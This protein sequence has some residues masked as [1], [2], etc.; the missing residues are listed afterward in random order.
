MDRSPAAVRLARCDHR[1][2]PP[3]A[4]RLRAL[5]PSCGP[6]RLVAVDGH[7]GSGKSTFAGRLAE[8]LGGAPV[9]HL[10]DLATH[11]EL[12]AWTD[13]LRAQVLEPLAAGRDRPLRR[14]TTGSRA[15]FAGERE[16]PPAPVVLLEGVG[17]GRRALRPHLARLLWMELARRARPGR[18]G[19][20]RD[21]PGAGALLGRLDRGGAT[22]TSRRTP[23]AR[24]R[25]SW[26]ARRMTGYE[27]LPGPPRRADR[28]RSDASRD[29]DDSA[30]A[31][32]R[33]RTGPAGVASTRLD[34]GGVQDLRSQCAV[35]TDRPQTRSPRLFPRD[36]GLRS[37]PDPV[38]RPSG[39]AFPHPA[40]PHLRA[41]AS[42][43][44]PALAASRPLRPARH[45]GYD[46]RTGRRRPGTEVCALRSTPV[47]ALRFG[48]DAGTRPAARGNGCVGT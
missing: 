35:A 22:R 7:A 16:L 48:A 34:L 27:V 41:V 32:R 20:L 13:R 38:R 15:A 42:T 19:R 30:A 4:P 36:R 47:P 18:R 14:R 25:I 31:R 23:P 40:S 10:D 6:V 1:I 33:R 44:G 24:S 45:R 5:P 21:G 9:V 2:W 26:C 8:A 12:F 43:H 39:P 29:G 3:L 46:A 37:V 11:E 17:A 28:T